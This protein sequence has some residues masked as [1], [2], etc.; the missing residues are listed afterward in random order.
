MRGK[1]GRNAPCPC[2]SGKKYKRCCGTIE[3]SS[4]NEDQLFRVDPKILDTAMRAMRA[5][6]S[7]RV[8][9]QGFGKPIITTTVGDT[10]FIAVKNTVHYSKEWKFFNDFLIY[11]MKRVVGGSW[12]SAAQSSGVDHPT[13]RWLRKL[14]D[15]SANLISENGTF[16]SHEVGFFTSIVRLGYSLYL[17]AHNDCIPNSL[18]RRLQTLDQFYPAYYETMVAAAFAVSGA[19]IESAEAQYSGVKGPEFWATGP[20]G[21]RYGVEAKRRAFWKTTPD[22]N[23]TAFRQ[24]LRGWVRSRLHEA[25]KKGINNPI[26]WLEL[27]IGEPFTEKDWRIIQK[28]I[29]EILIE[30]EDISV[31]SHPSPPAYVFVTNH[32]F[33]VNEEVAG[34]PQVIIF[35]TYKIPNFSS[36][37]NHKLQEALD[38]VEE[39]RDIHWLISCFNR[40][41][42]IPESFDGTPSVIINGR[43]KPL[44]TF[45]IGDKIAFQ[46]RD[47]SED[48]GIIVDVTATAGEAF[49]IV[50]DRDKS[51]HMIRFKLTED[52]SDA[53]DKYG[54]AVF[55]KPDGSN[56]NINGDPIA[57]YDWFIQTFGEFDRDSLLKQ[58]EGHKEYLSIASLEGRPLLVKVAKELTLRI[59]A[60]DRRTS[61]PNS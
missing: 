53:V 12:V 38:A 14:Q 21:K 46:Q 29:S 43:L 25:F 8:K 31:N 37:R 51:S 59:V 19:K 45:K 17:L 33:L 32:S 13:F 49:L 61:R 35:D 16:Q 7:I 20:S 15:H 34:S 1:V 40:I 18:I 41:Q 5:S 36:C 26:Y 6:E 56:R 24:E 42:Q 9:Q 23:S 39:N 58:V 22:V 52:V 11:Y 50:R 28:W 4:G 55:G 3:T 57:L 10:R 27:S 30:A 2:G 54:D 47:G 44:N 60:M 48:Q